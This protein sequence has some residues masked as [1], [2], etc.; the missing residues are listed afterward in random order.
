MCTCCEPSSCTRGLCSAKTAV[1]K[2]AA[3]PRPCHLCFCCCRA[4]H[5]DLPLVTPCPW[6]R[7]LAAMMSPALSVASTLP[8]LCPLWL[9]DL[10][11]PGGVSNNALH[12]AHWHCTGSSSSEEPKVCLNSALGPAKDT[13]CF[14]AARSCCTAAKQTDLCR[15]RRTAEGRRA[16]N[17][18]IIVGLAATLYHSTSGNLRRWCRKAGGCRKPAE[19]RWQLDQFPALG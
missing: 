18:I 1:C 6:C 3:C 8:P 5:H 19:L 10:G 17:S 14:H 2:I 13:L 9:L 12:G 11:E 16:G 7:G 15:R 4:E